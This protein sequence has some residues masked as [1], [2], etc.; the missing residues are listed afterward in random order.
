MVRCPAP[1]LQL[2]RTRTSA[3]HTLFVHSIST[4]SLFV[5]ERPVSFIGINYCYLLIIYYLLLIMIIACI[6]YL[7]YYLL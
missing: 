2:Y 4:L 6:N 3:A 7:I 5:R 1:V